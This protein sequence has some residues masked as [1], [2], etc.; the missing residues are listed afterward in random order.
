MFKQISK[1]NYPTIKSFINKHKYKV[2]ANSILDGNTKGEVF[3]DD[4][5]N[6]TIALIWDKSILVQIFGIINDIVYFNTIL[7]SIIDDYVAPYCALNNE[8]GL[9]IAFFP[10]EHWI[11]YSTKI[12]D[13]H[14]LLNSF[15]WVS[16]FNHQNYQVFRS[17]FNKTLPD[18]YQL[19]KVTQKVLEAEQN[20]EFI[21]EVLSTWTDINEFTAKGLGYCIIK[22]NKVIASAISCSVFNKKH[23]EISID[24]FDEQERNKGLATQCALAYI[25]YCLE[26]NYQPHWATDWDNIASQNLAT[27]IGFTGSVSENRYQFRFNRAENYLVNVFCHLRDKEIDLNY[28]NLAIKKAFEDKTIKANPRYLYSVALKLTENGIKDHVFFLL[29]ELFKSDIKYLDQIK[30]SDTFKQLHN[31]PEWK[32]LISKYEETVQLLK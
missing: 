1:E 9:L 26:N 21:E 27:K 12:I 20:I 13:D 30:K 14:Y 11:L 31:T 5:I 29:D 10:Q 19:C 16:E 24:T 28:I 7:K 17:R 25:D 3:A 6:P 22:N 4:A 18:G 8:T 15:R 23:Y 32:E 2:S